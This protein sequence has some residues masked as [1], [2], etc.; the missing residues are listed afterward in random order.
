MYRLCLNG[1]TQISFCQLEPP[2]RNEYF[3][4]FLPR[5]FSHLA[6]RAIFPVIF[7]ADLC[8]TRRTNSIACTLQRISM[9][10][11][12]IS[13]FKSRVS[14]LCIHQTRNS[15]CIPDSGSRNRDSFPNINLVVHLVSKRGEKGKIERE[16]GGG[17]KERGEF[18]THLLPNELFAQSGSEIH[19]FQFGC[20]QNAV[21][22]EL[23]VRFPLITLYRHVLQI[24]EERERERERERMRFSLEDNATT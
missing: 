12:E 18:H 7:Y 20:L 3:P 9:L 4:T 5:Y 13:R 1:R 21:L 11:Q 14:P 17:E 10:Q 8:K 2:K 24:P 16:R 22:G 15:P 19:D 6:E 23:D